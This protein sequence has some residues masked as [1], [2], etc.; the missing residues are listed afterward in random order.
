VTV[1][2]SRRRHAVIVLSDNVSAA[3]V[4]LASIPQSTAYHIPL[5]SIPHWASEIGRAVAGRLQYVDR[6]GHALP[7]SVSPE[8][9]SQQESLTISNEVA[10]LLLKTGSR[11]QVPAH[12][13]RAQDEKNTRTDEGMVTSGLV[14]QATRC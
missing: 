5:A 8:Y 12:D 10:P 6:R 11:V 14:R 9:A 13:A 4:P 2:D 7:I 3:I 1:H